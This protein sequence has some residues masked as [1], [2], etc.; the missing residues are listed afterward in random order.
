MS[1]RGIAVISGTNTVVAKIMEDKTAVF[2]VD[3]PI[4]LK[5]SG[6]LVINLTGSTAPGYLWVNGAGSASLT[7]ALIGDIS[8]SNVYFAPSGS[9]TSTN[10]QAAIQEVQTHLEIATTPGDGNGAIQFNNS[11]TFSGS[12]NLIYNYTTNVLSGTTSQFTTLTSSVVVPNRI[13][14][15]INAGVPTQQEGRIYYDGNTNHLEYWTE[16]N[17]ISLNL[18]QQ[19]AVRCQNQSGLTLSK[20]TVVHIVSSSNSGD[21]PRITTASYEVES[22]SAGTVGLLMSDV[23]NGS[24]TYVLLYGILTG[25]DTSEYYSGQP[26]YLSSS[27]NFSSVKPQ[28]PNHDVRIGNVVRVQSNNGSIFVRVQNGYELDEIH[29][30]RIT[31]KQNG[32]LLTYNSSNGLWANSQNLSGS[33]SVSGNLTV[34]GSTNVNNITI[35]GTASLSSIVDQATINFNSS[36]NRVEILPGLFI[37]GNIE[38]TASVSASSAQFG[39]V[40]AS[41]YQG[42]PELYRIIT[43]TSIQLDSTQCSVFAK[44]TVSSL[45]TITLP[46]AAAAKAKEYYFI[47]ADTISGSIRIAASGSSVI[48]GNSSF[49]LNGPYQSVTL[50]TDGSDWFVF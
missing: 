33:Y 43:T 22:H 1:N 39:T 31:S 25:I 34:T 50:I 19:I 23:I 3:A 44:N 10:V 37:K 14:F 12:S 9:I 24:Q 49:D 7:N 41:I 11:G 4:N 30:V 38:T 26:L 36:T 13:D 16:T 6:N 45:V 47:K 35:V 32:D 29:D 2:G 40:S 21:T 17:G 27:G 5:I 46:S 48:N 42:L 20:G 15:N 28:A 18:G 8:A